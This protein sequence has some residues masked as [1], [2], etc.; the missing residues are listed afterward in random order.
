LG[1]AAGRNVQIEYRWGADSGGQTRTLA[2]ELVALAPDVILTVGIPALATVKQVTSTVPVVF[3]K[4][5]I[6]SVLASSK[7]WRGRVTTPPDLRS[8]NTASAQ[9]GW[10]C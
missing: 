6:Q 1:R 8:L 3:V 5:S 7:A 10:S 4:P 9:N 2:A